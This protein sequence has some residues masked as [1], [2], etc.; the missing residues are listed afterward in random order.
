[1]PCKL[2]AALMHLTLLS[3]AIVDIVVVTVAVPVAGAVVRACEPTR[4]AHARLC[5][6]GDSLH[7]G[8]LR[9]GGL[10]Q[11]R[12]YMKPTAHDRSVESPQVEDVDV[13]TRAHTVQEVLGHDSRSSG[14]S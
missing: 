4:C 8:R 2:T 7:G 10:D 5:V 14:R 9:R 13:S 12:R 1:M 11:K 6:C 3:G